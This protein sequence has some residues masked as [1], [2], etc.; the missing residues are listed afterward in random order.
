MTWRS[1]VSGSIMLW[2]RAISEF[3]AI[4]ILA[5][6]VPFF[7]KHPAVAPVLIF[8]RFNN[9]GLDAARPIAVL[10]IVISLIAFVALRTLATKEAKS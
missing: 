8:E 9:F 3:G 1:V 6:H 7:G 10:V 4:L 5:Y 2:A